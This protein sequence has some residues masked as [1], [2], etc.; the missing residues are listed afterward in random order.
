MIYMTTHKLNPGEAHSKGKPI[1]HRLCVLLPP[2]SP[3]EKGNSHATRIEGSKEPSAQI[4]S[5][6]PRESSS[7][8]VADPDRTGSR[9]MQRVFYDS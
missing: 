2:S 7:L 8:Y 9:N 3:G 4:V 6:M 5:N 1:D